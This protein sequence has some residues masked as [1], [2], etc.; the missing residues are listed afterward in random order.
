MIRFALGSLCFLA[1]YTVTAQVR[2]GIG[3]S[4]SLFFVSTAIAE[5]KAQPSMLNPGFNANVKLKLVKKFNIHIYGEGGYQRLRF[6]DELNKAKIHYE[7]RLGGFELNYLP[8]QH[9]KKL[10][11]YGLLIDFAYLRSAITGFYRDA[12][13]T[14][15]SGNYAQFSMQFKSRNDVVTF[16]LNN[17]ATLTK[18]LVGIGCIS[19]NHLR[20]AL[21]IDYYVKALFIN[22][23]YPELVA[24]SSYSNAEV[25][26]A[27]AR[28]IFVKAGIVIYFG[29]M[30]GIVF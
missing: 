1:C 15:Y 14:N 29:K 27:Q 3:V 18:Y 8:F 22:K 20:K 2:F 25:Y 7:Q 30:K 23:P 28:K 26:L 19:E 21:I 9:K 12:Q 4:N 13:N 5:I 11:L 10:Q 6:K 17:T 16:D 24:H